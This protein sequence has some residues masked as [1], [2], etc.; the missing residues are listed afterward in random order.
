MLHIP[1][2]IQVNS[3]VSQVS[4]SL[5]SISGGFFATASNFLGG[6]FSF[7]IILVISFYLLVKEDGVAE[8]LEII[9]PLKQEEYFI[10]LWK[11]TQAKIGRWMQG[12][13]LLMLIVGVLI[14]FGLLILRVPHA[15]LLGVLAFICE[16][17]PVFGMTIAAIP[18]FLL[19][20][21]NGGWTLGLLVAGLYLIVQQFEAN[22]IYPL[23]VKKIVGIPPLLV[24]IS[25]II[26]AKLAGFLGI[27]LSV[28]LSVALMEFVEDVNKRKIEARNRH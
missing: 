5:A 27:I 13:L 21:L 22:V 1:Q 16:I 25:L 20:A 24:I 7:S 18:A 17:I 19:G 9:V 12:Q 6:V 26:G 23:V 11:R 28:P 10:G 4:A 3:L 8:F 14:Y 2:T 15:L